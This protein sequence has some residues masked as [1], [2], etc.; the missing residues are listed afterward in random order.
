[1]VQLST[2]IMVK[3]EGCKNENVEAFTAGRVCEEQWL[4]VGG[5]VA[6]I[7]V[8]GRSEKLRPGGE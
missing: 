8:G 5:V 1:M 4:G 3:G 6:Q 7:I 2:R